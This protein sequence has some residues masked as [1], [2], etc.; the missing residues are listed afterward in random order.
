[1]PR[2]RK[3]VFPCRCGIYVR[4]D[5]TRTG[6]EE[7]TSISFASGH[8]ARLKGFLIIAG[9]DGVKLIDEGRPD[10]SDPLDPMEVATELGWARQVQKGIDAEVARRVAKELRGMPRLPGM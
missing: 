5:G 3:R 7:R 2:V 6:C 9:A 8:D 10:G 4:T 1:M